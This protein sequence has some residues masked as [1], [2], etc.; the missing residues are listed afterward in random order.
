MFFSNSKSNLD[1]KRQV[2][3]LSAPVGRK[4]GMNIL[5]KCAALYELKKRSHHPGGFG[6]KH[7]FGRFNR[8]SHILVGRALQ[9]VR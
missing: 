1:M 7:A 4:S 3:P 8:E 2:I 6:Y 5:H 9:E